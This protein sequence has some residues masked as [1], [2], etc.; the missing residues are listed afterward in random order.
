ME[1]NVFFCGEKI[2]GYFVLH[3]KHYKNECRTTET[4]KLPSYTAKGKARNVIVPNCEACIKE[5]SAAFSRCAAIVVPA[6]EYCH[7]AYHETRNKII[8]KKLAKKV[9]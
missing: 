2:D 1:R 5:D 4:V 8:A 9:S 6:H 3:H 7:R